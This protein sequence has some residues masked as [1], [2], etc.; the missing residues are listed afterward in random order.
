[1]GWAKYHEDNVSRFWR[2]AKTEI[3]T[4]SAG[5]PAGSPKQIP[6]DKKNEPGSQRAGTAKGQ[7]V[8]VAKGAVWRPPKPA[9]KC[10]AQCPSQTSQG[11]A[12]CPS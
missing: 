9:G 3:R 7:S 1:M 6:I 12:T 5:R 2:D 10:R 11:R 4:E 8:A